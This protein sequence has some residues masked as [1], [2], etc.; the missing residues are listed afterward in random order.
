MPD[1]FRYCFR[2]CQD[3]LGTASRGGQFD[4]TY[5][6]TTATL[7]IHDFAAAQLTIAHVAD[8]RCCIASYVDDG[9]KDLRCRA[10]TRDHKPNLP[11]EKERVIAR[12]GSIT[13]DGYSN[14]RISA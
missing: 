14:H 12:G 7:C 11:D 4:A 6:G 8:S 1:M 10:L 5:S 9:Y 3:L 13:F 2:K